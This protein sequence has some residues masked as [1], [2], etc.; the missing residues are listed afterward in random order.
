[1][2]EAEELR[3]QIDELE[4][5]LEEKKDEIMDFKKALEKIYL[6]ARKLI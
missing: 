4:R 5:D 6:I 2:N 1:M 3:E